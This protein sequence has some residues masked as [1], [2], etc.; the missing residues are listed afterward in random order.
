MSYDITTN[1]GVTFK[2][3]KERKEFFSDRKRNHEELQKEINIPFKVDY[4]VFSKCP[5]E[6]LQLANEK[7]RCQ[8]C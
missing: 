5:A 2:T 7:L 6:R 4:S 8:N 3:E 1:L